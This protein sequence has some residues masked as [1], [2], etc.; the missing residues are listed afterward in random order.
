VLGDLATNVG[1]QACF[2]FDVSDK[3]KHHLGTD[4]VIMARQKA[5]LPTE[6]INNNWKRLKAG[7]NRRVWT[8]NYGNLLSILRWWNTPQLVASNG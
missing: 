2:Q 7:A 6:L 3:S 5:N 8:D 4:W 1:L